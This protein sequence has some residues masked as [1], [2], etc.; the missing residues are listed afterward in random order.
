MKRKTHLRQLMYV[1]KKIAQKDRKTKY[2]Q[3]HSESSKGTVLYILDNFKT[4]SLKKYWWPFRW[5]I[6]D[7]LEII[8]IFSFKQKVWRWNFSSLKKIFS[9]CPWPDSPRSLKFL[10]DLQEIKVIFYNSAVLILTSRQL[11]TLS[12]APCW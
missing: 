5:V 9:W 8:Q 6:F 4:L 11:L 7:T 3:A 10:L 1:V 12:G 2:L